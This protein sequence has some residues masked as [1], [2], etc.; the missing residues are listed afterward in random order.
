MF[1]QITFISKTFITFRPKTV[2]ILKDF[3]Y[4]CNKSICK[5]FDVWSSIDAKFRIGAIIN[6]YHDK[7]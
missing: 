7:I 5:H 1:K 4:D 3:V 6:I 2:N